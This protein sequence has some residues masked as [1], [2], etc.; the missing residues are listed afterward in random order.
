LDGW[1][2]RGDYHPRPNFSSMITANCEDLDRRAALAQRVSRRWRSASS[3]AL[4]N[5]LGSGG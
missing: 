5:F 3:H 4:T 2:I 1:V